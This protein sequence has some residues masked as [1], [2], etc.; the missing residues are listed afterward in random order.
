VTDVPELPSYRPLVSDDHAERIRRWHER[1][2]REAIAEAGS[3]RV[4]DYLGATIHVPPDVQPI[5]GVSHLLGEAVL[6]EVREGDRVLDVG[7]GSGVNAILAASKA[8]AVVAV[9]ISAGA[10]ETARA[11][12]AAN[13]VTG[14]VDVRQ[15]DVFDA[16]DGVFDLIVF[17]PPFRWFAPRSV[18]EA[19]TT[20][21]DYRALRRFFAHVREHLAVDGRIL[22]FFGSSGDLAY[23]RRLVATAGFDA[24]VVAEQS[25]AKD[26]WQVDYFTF[27]LT[28][29]RPTLDA[30]L[31][32]LARKI[33]DANLYMTLGT[34]DESGRP[35]ASPVYCAFDRYTEFW[36]VS[37]PDARH[38]RNIAVRPEVG[39][40]VF[41]S[42]VPISTGQAVYMS[43]VAEQV[44][45]A[46]SE[47][48]LDVFSQRSVAHGGRIWTPEDVLGAARVRL[49]RATA[50]EH[51]V[52]DP[53]DE[54]IAVQP[55]VSS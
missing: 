20:D 34:A 21:E 16:V 4:F 10:V 19:A 51:W 33:L 3:G 22:L 8:S 38:S 12:A 37:S 42:Q 32:E 18:L 36:W 7:T 54:R 26:G 27:R 23:V 1:A 30:D 24:Q 35:W 46:E 9:D 48:G 2:Y 39:I 6:A 55:H 53:R 45:G 44:T 14:R 31:A 28:D 17:D 15:S 29:R 41:D 50:S 47:R 11:N 43:A 40:V 49:Y 25:L 52:L 13:G 5:T